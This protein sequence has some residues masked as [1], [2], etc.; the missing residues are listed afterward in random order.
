MLGSMLGL[1][2]VGI[3]NVAVGGATLITFIL[4]VVN[5]PLAPIVAELYTSG[6]RVRLQ[7]V[8]TMSARVVLLGSLP[9]AIGLI[10]FGDWFL[11]IFG[12]EFAVGFSALI[13]LSVGEMVNASM[14]SVALLLNMTGNERDVAKGIGIAAALNIVLNAILIPIWGLIGAAVATT[15]S[16]AIWNIFMAVL[17]YKK[18]G[19]CSI[20]L[21]PVRVGKSPS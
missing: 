17:V 4:V 21:I 9:I 19:I 10:F 2:T 12:K 13:I 1:E 8:V 18:L 3:Y 14:G 16:M 6:N 20:A 15:I 5:M 11:L 7:R